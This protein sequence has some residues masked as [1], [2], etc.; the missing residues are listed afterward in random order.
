MCKKIAF[1]AE[2]KSPKRV[3]VLTT[4]SGINV[5]LVAN[6]SLVAND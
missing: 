1:T 6:N 3:V 2:A 5:M 4:Y